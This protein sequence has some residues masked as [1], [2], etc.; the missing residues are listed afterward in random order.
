MP[1]PRRSIDS[2]HPTL[3]DRLSAEDKRE[4]AA[5]DVTHQR[6]RQGQRAGTEPLPDD[7]APVEAEAPGTGRLYYVLPSPVTMA[8]AIEAGATIGLS[9]EA[10]ERSMAAL[11]RAELLADGPGGMTIVFPSGQPF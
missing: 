10:V 9:A 1:R 2:V 4:L 3:R 8:G 5:L 7:L 11:R 6:R